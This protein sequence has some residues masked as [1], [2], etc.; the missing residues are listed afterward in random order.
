MSRVGLIVN[1]AAGRDIRRLT[2]GASVVDNYAKRRVATCVLDGLTAVSEPPN[3][4]VMPDRRGISDHVL[5]EAPDDLTVETLEMTVESTAADTR[6]AASRS[7]EDDVDVVVALGGDGTTR[8]VACEIGDVPVVA[9]S[10]GTNNVVPTA[11]DGTVAGVAAALLATGAV[12]AADATTRH[13]MIEARAETAGG[14]QR[15]SALAAAEVSAQSFIGTRAL[16]DP[17]DLRGGVVSRAHPGD[18]GLAAIAGAVECLEPTEPGGVA[19]RLT[20]ADDAA[21]T[22]RAVLAP[23][24]TATVGI[25]SLERLEWNEPAEFDVPDGVVGADGERE[26]ELTETTVE[27]TPVPD[28]PRLVDIDATL[29]AGVEAGALEHAG[30][31]QSTED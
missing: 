19:V 8:D 3:V 23:G 28:G 13:G 16:L 18:I 10:T 24:V 7:R 4:A 26:L 17:S 20:E 1:P 12:P 30:R 6:R 25:E 11:V 14:T 31:L 9:V 5:E 15:L 2:G 21:R 29:S 22:V 27:L